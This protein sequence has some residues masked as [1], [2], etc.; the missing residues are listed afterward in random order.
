MKKD[1]LKSVKG[2]VLNK[3]QAK[4]ITGG[5]PLGGGCSYPICQTVFYTIGHSCNS[6]YNPNGFT[7]AYGQVW[8]GLVT[9]C[10]KYI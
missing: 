6:H 2:A 8:S 1:I 3:Q 4:T 9:Q 5:Y 10:L 7:M